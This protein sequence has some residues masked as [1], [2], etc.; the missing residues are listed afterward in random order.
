MIIQKNTNLNI[1]F[2]L[3]TAQNYIHKTFMKY[4]DKR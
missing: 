2:I 4:V 3:M 1:S